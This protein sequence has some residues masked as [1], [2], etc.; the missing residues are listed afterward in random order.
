M[1]KGQLR[2]NKEIRKPKKDK[3]AKVAAAPPAGSQV[4]FA[5]ATTAD[6]KKK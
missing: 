3:T 4:K 6:G 2:S 1:A 5:N